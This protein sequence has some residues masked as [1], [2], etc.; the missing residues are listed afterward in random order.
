M[1]TLI[2]FLSIK[3][4]LFIYLLMVY[5]P[6]TMAQSFNIDKNKPFFDL[7][8]SFVVLD[9]KKYDKHSEHIIKSIKSLN[10]KNIN[11]LIDTLFI[12]IQKNYPLDE[13][14]L[15]Y[16]NN[17]N[18]PFVDEEDI[19]NKYSELQMLS[20]IKE[21]VKK[22][23]LDNI[24]EDY[25]LKYSLLYYSLGYLD[26]YWYTTRDYSLKFSEMFYQT[27]FSDCFQL[28]VYHYKFP[29]NHPNYLQPFDLKRGY[30]E[31]LPNTYNES[32]FKKDE[33]SGKDFKPVY[34]IIDSK[35]AKQLLKRLS[36]KTPPIEKVLSFEYKLMMEIL[37]KAVQEEI[38]LL[39]HPMK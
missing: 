33:Y 1:K 37:Q 11:N 26:K 17:Y 34:S 38:Y 10:I 28:F 32:L 8:Q 19:K 9:K 20:R 16:L 35:K 14:L 15:F 2:N 7:H 6:I 36:T 39:V 5:N 22:G 21:D 23:S 25:L 12:D 3:K 13:I 27:Y 31:V 18:I 30:Y 24:S 29:L 4:I